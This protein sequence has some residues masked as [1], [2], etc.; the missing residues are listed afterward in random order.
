VTRASGSASLLLGLGIDPDPLFADL[1]DAVRLTAIELGHEP[2]E[3]RAAADAAGLDRL[4]LIGRP[5]RYRGLLASMASDG[6]RRIVWTG[7]PL[8]AVAGTAGDRHS[9]GFV[10]SRR[11]GRVARPLSKAARRFPLP[12]A[13]DRRR[14]ALATDR[15]TRAN[16]DELAMAAAAGADLVVTSRDR[17]ATLAAAG[18]GATVVP[19]GYHERHAGPLTAPDAGPRDVPL[20]MLGS[21]ATHT[22][23]ARQ[24]DDLVRRGA[25]SGLRVVEGIWGAEREALLRRT[26]VVVDVHR[27]PGNFVGLRLLLSLAA[28][29]AL[30][31]EPMTDPWPF[32]PGVHYLE[33]PAT[34]L[35]EVA[36]ALAADGGHRVGLVE[37]GQALLRDRLTMRASLEAVLASASRATS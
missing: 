4:L 14:V 33:A 19:F 36:T 35:L 2:S 9:A 27:I 21:R 15:L 23:R 11:R 10:E 8:P 29:A 5:G 3:V 1:I 12:A 18:L 25:G 13:L 16:L 30:V 7:E 20:L 34:E 22:R 6:P 24:V 26:C 31:T 37:A 17:G 28:G 32:V